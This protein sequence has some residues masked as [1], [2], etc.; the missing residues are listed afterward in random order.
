MF[1]KYYVFLESYT[2]YVGNWSTSAL[3]IMRNIC[4]CT[5]Y[6]LH[7]KDEDNVFLNREFSGWKVF[8]DHSNRVVFLTSLGDQ[9]T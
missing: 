4:G 6:S 8:L 7:S 1:R 2:R 9:P 5:L 3:V